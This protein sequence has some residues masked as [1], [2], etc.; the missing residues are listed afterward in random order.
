MS[1]FKSTRVGGR[2][3]AGELRRLWIIE[4]LRLNGYVRTSSLAKAAGVAEMTIR[5]D[6]KTLESDGL[7]V[8]CHGGAIPARIKPSVAVC[9]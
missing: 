6:L 1:T 3:A 4:R 5:R 8:V 7:L 9:Q 2:F